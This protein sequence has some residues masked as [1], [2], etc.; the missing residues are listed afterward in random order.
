MK[1]LVR[2]AALVASRGECGILLKEVRD[3]LYSNETSLILRRDLFQR[4]T[5]PEPKTAIMLRRL[6]TRDFR[7][8]IKER[9]RRLPVLLAD[10]PTCY[11]TVTASGELTFMLWVVFSEDWPR[12]KPHFKG[13]IPGGLRSD[14][15]LFEFAYTF[16]KFRGQGVMA[17]SLNLIAEE[18]WRERPSVRWA[19]NFVRKDNI[20][21][22]K[23]CRTAGFVPYMTREERWRALRLNQKFTL[24]TPGTLFPFETTASGDA[25][26]ASLKHRAGSL[27]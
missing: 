22:L 15:C 19:Y 3:R 10:I 21:S 2:T 13:D 14:E 6:E 7:P 12:F 1:H 27:S 24:L 20:P 25:A 17:A 26:R 11:V 9:P 23:G 18:A 5:V 4:R 8:I 16:E